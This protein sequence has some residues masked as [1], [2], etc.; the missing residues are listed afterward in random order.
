V[1]RSRPVPDAHTNALGHPNDAQRAVVDARS[2]RF[3]LHPPG[4]SHELDT[5]VIAR[6][7]CGRAARP[8]FSAALRKR[9]RRIQRLRAR[10]HRNIWSS[11]TGTAR[12]LRVIGKA[13]AAP[14]MATDLVVV[15]CATGRVPATRASSAFSR[16]PA[17]PRVEE[18]VLAGSSL[19]PTDAF[20]GSDDPGARTSVIGLP[21]QRQSL[22]VRGG[23]L[24]RPGGAFVPQLEPDL[25]RRAIASM[26]HRAA[27]F[28]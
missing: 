7:S 15:S 27:G 13:G 21:R 23:L 12:E 26:R 16:A 9:G 4:A 8:D 5:C 6:A 19:A 20:D 25:A 1:A 3:G 22:A 24:H 28:A 11:T 10:P 18:P 14:E 17:S 2:P